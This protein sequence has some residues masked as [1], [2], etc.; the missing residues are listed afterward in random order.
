[1]TIEIATTTGPASLDGEPLNPHSL[2]DWLALPVQHFI[3]KHRDKPADELINE[4]CEMVAELV[5]SCGNTW[6]SVRPWGQFAMDSLNQAIKD[7]FA[8]HE[9][10]RRQRN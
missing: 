9:R 1:M 10:A 2:H 4:A 8:A 5:N 6:A 3:D 7:K